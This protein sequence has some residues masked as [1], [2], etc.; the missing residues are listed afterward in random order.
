MPII[1]KSDD[2]IAIMREAGS[3][4]ARTMQRLL[5]QLEPGLVVNK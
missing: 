3:I 5:A 2:E 4:V 1:I